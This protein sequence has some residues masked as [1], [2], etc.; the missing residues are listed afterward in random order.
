MRNFFYNISGG[1]PR[2]LLVP[3]AAS[4]ADGLCKIVPAAVVFD[5]IA[6]L[7]RSFAHGTPLDTPRLWT[8]CALLAAWALLQ[9]AVSGVAYQK[10]FT[11]SYDASDRGRITLVDHLRTLS[12]G[13]IGGR[14]PGEL[15]TMILG[16]FTTVETAIS[17]FTPQ[18]I[19]AAALPL[20][21]LAG[22]S[23]VDWRMALAMFLPLPLSLVVVALSSG[24]Q[25]RLGMRHVRAKTD[26]ASR[27]Q[28]YL[29]GMR[30]IKAHS[31]GGE[32]FERLREAF[33]RLMRESIRLE[34]IVGSVMLP[35]IAIL[36]SGLAIM[37]FTGAYLLS[38]GDLSLPVFLMF[39]V[40]GS[41][42]FEPMTMVFINYAEI[43][44]AALSAE[45]IMTVRREKPLPGKGEAPSGAGAVRFENVS[46]S[47]GGDTVL[48]NVSFTAPAGGVT[49]LVGPSG[50]GKSTVM[51]LITR[52]WD[53]QGGRIL[54]D[55]RD[56]REVD[57]EKLLTRISMVF[58]DVYLFRDTIRNNIRAAK[59]HASQG[60]I[61]QAARQACCHEF[62]MNL[63]EGY[64]TLVGEGG[65]TLSGGEK[66][67]VSIAR[68]LL[69]DAPLVLLDE[70]TASLDPENEI[71]VQQAVGA[72]V[73][74][75]TVIMIAHR[76]KTVMNADKILVLD[77]GLIA[78]EGTHQELLARG[79]LYARLWDLQ[80]KSA[81]W[82]MKAA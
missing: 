40:V 14:D 41:R 82:R 36:R 55:G 1:A 65:C 59:L 57:P 9:Y 74:N 11:A 68:A 4:F 75:R 2:T 3:A 5:V 43:R 66:Q 70:P 69:K 19:S 73:G 77:G 81:G 61:E 71:R 28:E 79:G 27:L 47:Y 17:H 34:G 30:E 45:R 31:M 35:A 33:S 48:R 54:L 42:V 49:A 10:T 23:F 6:T 58:Q 78:E 8:S 60:E 52:F 76:L 39:L 38:R 56:I 16:D 22:L 53:V 18:L 25:T 29:L 15:T 24:L 7:F 46:F 67:R 64:D 50:G 26:S 72:L 80:R 37:I 63:P 12:L 51:R 13:F 44:Y 62:I 20:V 21:A 32:R